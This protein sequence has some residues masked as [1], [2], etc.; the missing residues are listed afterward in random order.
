MTTMTAAQ[1]A[2]QHVRG[3][4]GRYAETV[5]D[6][7]ALFELEVQPR[8]LQVAPIGKAKLGDV[9]AVDLGAGPRQVV[10]Q[11]TSVTGRRFVSDDDGQVWEVSASEKNVPVVTAS[12]QQLECRTRVL[13]AAHRH[14]VV[15]RSEWA[16]VEASDEHVAVKTVHIAGCGQVTPGTRGLVNSRGSVDDAMKAHMGWAEKG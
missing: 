8:P 4:G 11:S 2:R 12:P 6:E 10:V 9:V 13:S 7:P 14:G 1:Q 5:H 16:P 15:K 3:S